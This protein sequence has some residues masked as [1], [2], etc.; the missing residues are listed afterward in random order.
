MLQLACHV[1]V[2][3]GPQRVLLKLTKDKVCHSK[4]VGQRGQCGL[5]RRLGS[6]AEDENL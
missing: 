5:S 4:S 2:Q 6:T 3:I 1:S